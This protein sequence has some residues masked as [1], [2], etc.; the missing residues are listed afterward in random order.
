MAEMMSGVAYGPMMRSTC[1]WL[2][3]L[4]VEHEPLHRTPEQPALGVEPLDE[5]VSGDLVDGAGRR[6]RTGEGQR[7]ADDDR[8]ARRRARGSRR[9]AG[10]RWRRGAG[11]LGRFGRRA[12]GRRAAGHQARRDEHD[13]ERGKARRSVHVVDSSRCE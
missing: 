3:G 8:V 4:V 1:S 13:Q 6:Q 12:V 5:Q 11:G 10:R 9:I 7:R 2:I